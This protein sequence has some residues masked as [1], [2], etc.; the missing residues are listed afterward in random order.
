MFAIFMYFDLN[1][2]MFKII[3]MYFH[4]L[5]PQAYGPT[6]PL[7]AWVC[8]SA[9]AHGGG[10]VQMHNCCVRVHVCGC[11]WACAWVCMCA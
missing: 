2:S 11:A 9:Y 4:V 3:F 1:I 6:E 7:N 8:M 10:K 5:G